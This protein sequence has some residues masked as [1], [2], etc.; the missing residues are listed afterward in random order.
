MH[1]NFAEVVRLQIGKLLD[2]RV[3]VGVEKGLGD[4]KMLLQGFGM[5]SRSKW[6]A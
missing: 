2:E 4:G 6:T 3:E 5:V 1:P